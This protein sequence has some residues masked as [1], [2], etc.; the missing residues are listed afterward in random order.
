[1]KLGDNL[2][3]ILLEIAQTAIQ[4]GN[5]EKAVSTYTESLI[6]F[7]EDYVIKLLKNEYVLATSKDGV[8]VELTDWEMDTINLH[9]LF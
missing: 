9:E 5:P 1:M 8:S 3:E 6:G 4:E 2:G 7:T